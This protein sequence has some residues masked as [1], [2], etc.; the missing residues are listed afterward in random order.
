MIELYTIGHSTRTIDEFL[1]IL[2]EFQ[3]ALLADVRSLPGS[4]KFPHF[5]QESLQLDLRQADIDY[6]WMPQLGGRRRGAKGFESPNV[7]LRSLSFRHYADYMLS[8]DF[9]EGIDR[10][11]ELAGRSRAAFMCAEAVYWRCHR[12]LISDYLVTHGANARHIMG[13]RSIR[14]HV[15]TPGLEVQAN[16]SLVYLPTGPSVQEESR[17]AA[18][19][20]R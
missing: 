14:P 7:G 20:G 2:K 8:E 13:R 5:N 19:A 16:G 9:R 12:R 10:L 3:I 4:G 18:G 1:A 17:Q 11:V 15:L 6:V